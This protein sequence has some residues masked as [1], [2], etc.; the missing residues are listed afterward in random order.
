[1]FICS[2]MGNEE[3][4]FSEKKFELLLHVTRYYNGAQLCMQNIII[5]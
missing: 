5:C 1:M 2:A 3:W 4:E